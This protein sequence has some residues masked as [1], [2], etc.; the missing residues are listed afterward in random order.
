MTSKPLQSVV[1]FR[2][3]FDARRIVPECHLF[4]EYPHHAAASARTADHGANTA[5]C[6][7]GKRSRINKPIKPRIA[8]PKKRWSWA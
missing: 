7:L 8:P 2:L 6:M 4:P 3:R 5:A 1:T